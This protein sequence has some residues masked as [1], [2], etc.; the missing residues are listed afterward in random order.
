MYT[1]T[2]KREVRIFSEKNT[3]AGKSVVPKENIEEINCQAIDNLIAEGGSNFIRYLGWLNMLNQK[4]I[5]LLSPKHHYFFDQS[6]LE[7]PTTLILLKRLNQMDNLNG[8][9]DGI[10]KTVGPGTSLMGHFFASGSKPDKPEVLS[11]IYN[12]L[13]DILDPGIL[14]KFDSESVADLIESYGFEVTDLT[15]IKNSVYFRAVKK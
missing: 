11:S 3:N 14:K 1:K 9:L 15:L 6:E 4:N 13:I 7:T 10:S 8:F 2:I 12:K 5:L